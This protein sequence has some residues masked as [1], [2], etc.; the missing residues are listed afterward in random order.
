M[1]SR[2]FPSKVYSLCRKVPAGKVSTYKEIAR[3]L[4]TNGYR[5]V[6]Q[7]L[8]QSPGM[9]SVPCHR[10]ICSDGKVGG[11]AQGTKK[12]IELLR[13]EGIIVQKQRV[14]LTQYLF[15]L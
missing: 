8:H 12:K 7:A 6:G 1:N 13:K 10:I 2:P 4:N 14:D 9:P 11:F 15:R 5:A 3:Q